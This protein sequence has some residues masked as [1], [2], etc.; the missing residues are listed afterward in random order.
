MLWECRWERAP[1]GTCQETAPMQDDCGLERGD[2][3][4]KTTV[5]YCLDLE[6]RKRGEA[7]EQSYICGLF[8][9]R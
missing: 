1:K 2:E 4:R 3:Q 5:N 8:V 9:T 7:E 6:M